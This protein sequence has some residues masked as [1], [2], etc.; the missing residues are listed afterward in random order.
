MIMP[1]SAQNAAATITTIQKLM[2]M[3]G[4][5]TGAAP[6]KFREVW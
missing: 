4:A 2:W 6:K 5:S 3:P 1:Q